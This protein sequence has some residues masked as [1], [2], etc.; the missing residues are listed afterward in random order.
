MD[1]SQRSVS[2]LPQMGYAELVSGVARP[3]LERAGQQIGEGEVSRNAID[4]VHRVG[5]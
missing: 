1:L 4:V 5:R 3:Q 2:R